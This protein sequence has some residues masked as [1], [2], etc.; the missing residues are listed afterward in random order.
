MVIYLFINIFDQSGTKILNRNNKGVANGSRSDG[1]F[2]T[3]F[4][5]LINSLVRAEGGTNFTAKSNLT[6]DYIFFGVYGRRRQRQ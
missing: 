3:E 1:V 4:L 6:K 5:C 2:E